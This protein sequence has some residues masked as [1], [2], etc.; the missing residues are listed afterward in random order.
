MDHPVGATPVRGAGLRLLDALPV[1]V[2]MF[3]PSEPYR[4]MYRN[5]VF[6]HWAWRGSRPDRGIPVSDVLSGAVIEPGEVL[7]RA[8]QSGLPQVLVGRAR[9]DGLKTPVA[10]IS[11]IKGPVTPSP[12]TSVL[13]TALADPVELLGSSLMT[14]MLPGVAEQLVNLDMPSRTEPVVGLETVEQ[15]GLLVDMER[16]TVVRDGKRRRLTWTEWQLF[17]HFVRHPGVTFTRVQLAAVAWGSGAGSRA[18]EVDVY[19]SRLRRKVEADPKRPRLI[20]TIRGAGY[21]LQPLGSA[22]KRVA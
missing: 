11:V 9:G 12:P 14:G 13:L 3:E 5:R 20:A 10:L 17:W 15:D 19:I 7:G 21:R 18:A 6:A 8:V 1:G 4:C 2:A 16:Q 22:A